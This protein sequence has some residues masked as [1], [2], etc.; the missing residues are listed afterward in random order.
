MV[1]HSCVLNRMVRN[2]GATLGMAP[3]VW[4]V[5]VPVNVLETQL[6]IA[7]HGQQTSSTYSL[8]V[9]T[10]TEISWVSS[11]HINSVNTVE[12]EFSI[13]SNNPMAI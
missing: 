13:T 11:V 5:D 6:N 10:T 7:D 1:F 3:G 2:V 4:P 12:F 8:M 9:S